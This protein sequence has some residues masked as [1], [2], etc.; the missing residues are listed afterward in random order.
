MGKKGALGKDKN[1]FTIK[2]LKVLLLLDWDDGVEMYVHL[3]KPKELDDR[4]TTEEPGK[5]D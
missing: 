4:K 3:E 1:L 5:T 2:R